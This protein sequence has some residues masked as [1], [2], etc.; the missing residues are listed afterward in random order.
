M[1]SKNKVLVIGLARSG[2]NSALFL[3]KEGADILIS[4]SKSQEQLAE[5]INDL[6]KFDN[7][8][9][10]LGRNPMIDE[11]KDIDFAVVSPGVP[12]ELEYI[13]Q[14]KS[15]GISVISEIELAYKVAVKKGV[16][17]IGITGTNGK[18]TT[19]SILG[20]I[21]KASGKETYV[22]G[23]IGN[24]A[25]KA[26]DEASENAVLVTELSSFQLESID[27][28]KPVVSTVLNLTEDHMD[29]HHTI[30]N[31][32][33]AKANIFKNQD[34]DD[35][36][37]LNYDDPITR[38][39]GDECSARVIYFSV[40]NILPKGI[41]LEDGEIIINIDKKMSLMKTKDLSLPGEHNIENCM[42]AIGVALSYGV[43]E[44]V[45]KDVLM[46]F[47]A[48]EH[49]LE[50]VNTIN[51]VKYVNDSKGTNPDSTIKA[52][53]SY[54]QPIILIAGGYDKG[55]DF[56]ELFSIAK[57]YVRT[58]IVLGQTSDLIYKT[59]KDAGIEEI[60]K[61]DSI[62]QA[63]KKA[64]EVAD[65]NNVVLLSPACASWGMYNNYEERGNDFKK[66]VS[67]I[68]NDREGK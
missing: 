33:M 38:K 24:P 18:T 32:A 8:K 9:Y 23:N 1:F 14:L 5:I 45:I 67:E 22:V 56:T 54:D 13:T 4:D 27:L 60:F 11:V 17:F 19:T 28:F 49:R 15:M 52:V 16:S 43:D 68:E 7:V 48:V 20:E 40:K 3:A 44:Q 55:S 46:T 35:F 36:C 37:I 59:A 50:Y 61:V 66:C 64:S 41:Y 42:A 62:S 57:K 65:F 58:V 25:I 31:Y 34:R 12:L 2:I 10:I 26:V 63:V 47:K 30:E 51:G 29:R 39:M 6:D 53:Q 21:I